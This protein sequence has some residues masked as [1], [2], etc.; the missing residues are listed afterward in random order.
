MQDAK[1]STA[2]RPTLSDI[3]FVPKNK[4]RLDNITGSDKVSRSYIQTAIHIVANSMPLLRVVQADGGRSLITCLANAAQL[5][6]LPGQGI[7]AHCYFVP[8]NKKVELQLSYK[9]LI[10]LY[11]RA[12]ISISHGIVRQGDEYEFDIGANHLSHKYDPNNV[13]AAPVFYYA[14]ARNKDGRI[15]HIQHMTKKQLEIHRDKFSKATGGNVWRDHFDAMAFKTLIRKMS[16]LLPMDVAPYIESDDSST[17]PAIV[18]DDGI[19]YE[20]DGS[21]F[22]DSGTEDNQKPEPARRSN[23]NDSNEDSVLSDD[24]L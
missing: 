15:L 20:N 17:P 4:E 23:I 22:G 2:K 14:I 18:D 11:S 1:P 24:Q 16:S 19:P 8:Y 21:D 13:S 7:T 9:G 3:I 12:G 10:V 5:R 6:L